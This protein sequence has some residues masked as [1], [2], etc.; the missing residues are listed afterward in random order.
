[1]GTRDGRSVL[2]RQYYG[3]LTGRGRKLSP[4][5]FIIAIDKNSSIPI[6]NWKKRYAI[7]SQNCTKQF[8]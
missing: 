1:M 8:G 3:I 6:H 5:L 4:L 2:I 7:P